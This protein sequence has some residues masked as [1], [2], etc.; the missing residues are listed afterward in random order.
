LRSETRRIH[1]VEHALCGRVGHLVDDAPVRQ[2]NDPVGV[3]GRARV[4]G[5]D[6]D[7]LTEPADRV[8]Q[9]PQHLAA[10]AGVEVAGRLVGEDDVGP[11]G[12]RA[13]ARHPLL[14]AAGHLGRAVA[15]PIADTERLDH[16][17]E[18][19]L[20]GFLA[21]DIHRQGDVLQRRQRRHQVER[22]EDEPD[23]V[24]AQLRHLLV[25]QRRQ[26]DVGDAHRTGGDVV[27]AGQAVHQRR[28]A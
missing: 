11:A 8:A 15:E 19:G 14:L 28:L 24:P 26:L 27:E 21:G 6:D 10:R 17:V 13:G 23:P 9:D 3:A 22:L 5:D 7:G 20:I 16:R 4:V 18:P 2:E 12:Q 25:R 1:V